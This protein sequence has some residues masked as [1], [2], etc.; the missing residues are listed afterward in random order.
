MIEKMLVN[1]FYTGSLQKENHQRIENT[2]ENIYKY[3]KEID[4]AQQEIKQIEKKHAELLTNLQ[5]AL[6]TELPRIKEIREKARQ[7]KEIEKL[8]AQEIQEWQER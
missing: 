8:L 4:Q 2:Q 1:S 5:E 7:E 6:N 3:S